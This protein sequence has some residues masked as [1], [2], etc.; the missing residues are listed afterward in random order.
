MKETTIKNQHIT[1]Y[2]REFDSLSEFY[3]YITKT[4]YGIHFTGNNY[5]ASIS[6]SESFTKTKN[7]EEA[8]TLFKNGWSEEAIKLT[9]LLKEAVKDTQITTKARP[10][11][12]VQGYQCSVPR[13]LQGLPDSMINKKN[14]PVKQKII[15]I[16]KS[17][18]YNC[19]ATTS[20]IEKESIKALSLINNIES[21]GYRCNLNVIW[22]VSAGYTREM[23]KVRIK[24]ANERINVTK[25]AFP[26][27]HPSM[28]RRLL[29]RYLEVAPS[30]TS[31]YPSGYGKPDN[32]ITI[33]GLLKQ[34]GYENEFTLPTFLPSD[35]NSVESLQNL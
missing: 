35:I 24:S 2:V 13:Y 31:S 29:F 10:T 30:V 14:I 18:S 21:Q 7:F 33:K 28:L 17:V 32:N 9:H 23:V 8:V 4:A 15:T 16:N 3:D 11:Y 22:S 20:E 5:K 26:L 12:S 6:G 1:T 19:A 34:M 27:V 25:L